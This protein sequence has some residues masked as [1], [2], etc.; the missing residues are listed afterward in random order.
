MVREGEA[1]A[2]APIASGEGVLPAAADVAQ[3]DVLLRAGRRLHALHVAL[4]AMSGVTS[5]AIRVPRLRI[6]RTRPGS[7]P[8]IDAAIESITHSIRQKGGSAAVCDT[9]TALERALTQ[10]DADAAVVVGGTGCGRNDHAVTTLAAV[11]EVDVHGI[12]LVPGETAAFGMVGDRPALLLP[13]RFDAA[14]AVWHMLGQAMLAWLAANEEQPCMRA[15]KLTRKLS[16][17]A[18]LAEL[19]PVRCDSPL[20][21]PLASG[22]AP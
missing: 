3:G 20:A 18:G 11:G 21:T 1:Q 4:L 16:S 12:A 9:N 5:V 6:G 19:V 22:Y 15:A 2:L 8:V 10:A 17:S 13:G 14:L 7:D